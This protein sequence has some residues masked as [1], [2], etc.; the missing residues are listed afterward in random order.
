MVLS[1]A[2]TLLPLSAGA[3]RTFSNVKVP[4]SALTAHEVYQRDSSQSWRGRDVKGIYKL[5]FRQ[6]ALN[7]WAVTA[8]MRGERGR[9]ELSPSHLLSGMNSWV[10]LQVSCFGCW[11]VLSSQECY[12]V[13]WEEPSHLWVSQ[14]FKFTG[15]TIIRKTRCLFAFA[16]FSP[17]P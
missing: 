17:P 11:A 4:R 13:P 3:L 5:D 7:L 1:L 10:V 12:T 6:R 16:H 2:A 15:Q 14:G 8:Q 9:K